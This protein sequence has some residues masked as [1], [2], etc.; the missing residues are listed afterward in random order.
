M[1][2]AGL[3]ASLVGQA[4][5]GISD[6]YFN[7][8]KI[9]QQ[10]DAQKEMMKYQTELNSPK[11]QRRRFE[12]AGLNPALMMSSGGAGAVTSA[13]AAGLGQVSQAG[14]G[15]N[16]FEVA[17]QIANLALVKSQTRK[18]NAEAAKD[19]A[20]ADNITQMTPM[21][22]KNLDL[23]NE[24]LGTTNAMNALQLKLA[25]LTFETDVE[26][27]KQGLT[28]LRAQ[29]EA[30]LANTTATE[31]QRDLARKQIER[32]DKMLPSE[33]KVNESVA[34]RNDAEA[35]NADARTMTENETRNYKVE[36]LNQNI[37]RIIA[38][39]Y[40]MNLDN[41][42]KEHNLPYDCAER[43]IDNNWYKIEKWIA[44]GKGVSEIARNLAEAYDAANRPEDRDA[45]RESR[46]KEGS[47]NRSNKTRTSFLTTL[48][49]VGLSLLFK[50]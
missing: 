31:A 34:N 22:I 27:K 24:G 7:G 12:E 44:A 29:Y 46:E 39:R 18:N 41:E 17:S 40:G 10:V 49:T 48:L 11:N 26:I 37:S 35:R 19:E 32:I 43:I 6:A 5:G 23:Q 30:V 47:K 38:E 16:A 50:K 45:D 25:D 15:R 9:N 20:S 8:I 21:Q 42:L 2:G 28:N 33:I 36:E 3:V 14:S 13:A 1:I 4:I